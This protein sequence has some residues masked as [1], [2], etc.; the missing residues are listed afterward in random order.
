M[1]REAS[2]RPDWGMVGLLVLVL[3]VVVILAMMVTTGG[4]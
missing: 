4:R 1:I 2:N 3:F